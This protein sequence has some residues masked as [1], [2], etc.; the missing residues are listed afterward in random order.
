[1][2]YRCFIKQ[3]LRNNSQNTKKPCDGAFFFEKLL[4]VIGLHN[5]Q[6]W[7]LPQVLLFEFYF[8][9]TKLPTSVSNVTLTDVIK[10]SG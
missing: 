6:E 3:L 2:V 5:Y 10:H 8:I 9:F 1:M 7:T 4:L